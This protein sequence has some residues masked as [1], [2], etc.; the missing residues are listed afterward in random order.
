[1]DP[2]RICI[3]LISCVILPIL[4]IDVVQLKNESGTPMSVVVADRVVVM[5]G[6]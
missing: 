6:E 1:M 2:P 3:Q 4:F 5:S